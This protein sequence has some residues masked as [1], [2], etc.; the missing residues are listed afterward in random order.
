MKIRTSELIGLGLDW[1]VAQ[2]RGKRKGYK[3]ELTGDE[4]FLVPYSP[5]TKGEQGEPI[6]EE[7]KI[8]SSYGHGLKADLWFAERYRSYSL[9]RDTASQQYGPTAL[10]AC[11][12]S[13]VASEMGEEVEVPYELL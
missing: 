3:H 2:C 4:R 1:A 5:S 9:G 10:V 11:M 8:N 7:Y 12:R 13:F 6:I